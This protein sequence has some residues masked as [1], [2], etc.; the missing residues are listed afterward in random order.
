MHGSNFTRSTKEQNKTKL[1][2]DFFVDSFWLDNIIRTRGNID[3]K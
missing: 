1:I 3:Y 2:I